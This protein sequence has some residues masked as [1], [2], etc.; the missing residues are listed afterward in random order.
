MPSAQAALWGVRNVREWLNRG[1]TMLREAG[2]ADPGYSQL[3]LRN[4][5]NLGLIPGPRMRSAGNAISVTGGHGDEDV[6]APD[7]E[8]PR[9]PNLADTVDEVAR[10]VRRDVKYGA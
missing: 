10:A 4:S 8:L 5:I 2:E 6:L 3:A 1:F 7:Q 9:R